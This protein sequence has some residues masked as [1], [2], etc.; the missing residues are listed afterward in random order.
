M[1]HCIQNRPGQLLKINGSW[2]QSLKISTTM[3]AVCGRDLYYE[4]RISLRLE[5]IRSEKRVPHIV[6]SLYSPLGTRQS[7]FSLSNL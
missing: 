3:L 1:D 5:T 6:L 7:K 2:A 4:K